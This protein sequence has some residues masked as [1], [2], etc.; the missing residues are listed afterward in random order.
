MKL[1]SGLL[2]MQRSQSRNIQTTVKDVFIRTLS[3]FSALGFFSVD[4]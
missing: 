2:E 3:T 4:L 1:I